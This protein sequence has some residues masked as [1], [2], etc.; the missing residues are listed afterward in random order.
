MKCGPCPKHFSKGL[1][2]AAQRLSLPAGHAAKAR[3][4][5]VPAHVSVQTRADFL[6]T[7]ENRF[8]KMVLEA[9][10]DF[11]S[12][13]AKELNKKRNNHSQ[14]LRLLASVDR[15]RG[16][17]ETQLARGFLPDVSRPEMLPLGSPVLQRKAGYRELLHFW[18]QFHVGAQLACEGGAEVFHAGSRN[19]ATLYECW[20]FFQL[21]A[22][23]RQLF[24]CDQPLHALLINR[25]KSPPRLMLKRGFQLNMPVSG[26]WSQ[27]AR[28]RLGAELHFNRKFS[29]CAKLANGG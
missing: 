29:L 12:A 24:T 15:L 22:L 1:G 14:T 9:F 28:R 13:I 7:A 6:D 2:L 26:V 8:V 16:M 19:V 23:F 10:K 3:I 4:L 18:L 20:L 11:L 17:L 25:E 27:T 5:S 21:E